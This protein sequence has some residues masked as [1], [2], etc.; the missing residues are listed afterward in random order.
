M[1]KSFIKRLVALALVIVS[2]FAVTAVAFADT[3]KYVNVTP[4][5]NFRKTPGGALIDRIPYGAAVTEHS[6]SYSGNEQWSYI[7][8]NR[9]TGY[10]MTKYLSTTDPN[11]GNTHPTSQ[12]QA[13]GTYTLRQGQT[14]YYVKNLQL[15]LN[16]LGY[17]AG[18]AD[19]IFGS[20]TLAAVQDFQT[21]N[22]LTVDGLVGSATKEC[23]WNLAGDYLEDEGV[24]SL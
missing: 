9:T 11:G 21:D 16:D 10:V 22:G 14:S 13:F 18:T 3:T 8:Y 4:N 15:A 19:G 5:V 1:K 12:S 20:N 7:T 24:M 6:T 23:L 17:G 2:V